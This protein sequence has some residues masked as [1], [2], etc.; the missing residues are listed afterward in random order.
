MEWMAPASAIAL[1]NRMA[2]A[3]RAML[4]TGETWR[5]A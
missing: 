5:A 1:A 4:K 3:I 2:R